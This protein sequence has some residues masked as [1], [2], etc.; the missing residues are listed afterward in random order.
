MRRRDL[1]RDE[2]LA[3]L[4]GRGPARSPSSCYVGWVFDALK[5]GLRDAADV[6]KHVRRP[7]EVVKALLPAE[8]RG[9]RVLNEGG[10][11]AASSTDMR[12]GA[13]ALAQQ[14][15]V[16]RGAL[17]AETVVEGGTVN[18]AAL[19]GSS[20]YGA[21]QQAASL[22]PAAD[23]SMLA[24]DAEKNAF[25]INL[26]NV[27]AIHG[28]MALGIERSV[29]E[30]PAFF[31][32]VA[33]RVG[34]HLFTLDDIENG[35]LR[36]NAAHPVSKRALFGPGDA[37]LHLLP[38]RADARIHAALVCASTSCPAVRFYDADALDTQLDV[39]AAAY[40]RGSVSTHAERR[41]VELPVT[42]RYYASDFGPDGALAFVL[43]HAV[44]GHREELQKAIDDGY[45]VIYARYDW[46]LNGR[47]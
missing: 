11:G 38:E 32:W 2:P 28:V 31:A 8:V 43:Q 18:Y 37:R 6:L 22:L 1:F 42:F 35:V 12:V 4:E 17:E 21:L 9:L 19:R 10:D 45:G 25:W 26:Y 13:T 16:L 15:R 41:V 27:L 29:M 3:H 44:G 23:L 40:V 14:L 46:S 7:S 30:V 5:N 20:A 24:T 34:E 47:V 36:A 33:Y 39:A